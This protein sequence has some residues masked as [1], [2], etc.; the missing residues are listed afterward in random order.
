[1]KVSRNLEVTVDVLQSEN[2]LLKENN[3]HLEMISEELQSDVEII[4]ESVKMVGESTTEFMT[5]LRNNYEKLKQENDRHQK[6][7]RQQGMFQLMQLFKHFD[8]N[9]DFRLSEEE[10]EQNEIYLKSMFPNYD[11]N[12]FKSSVSY[13]ELCDALLPK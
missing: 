11:S 4:T 5:K 2:D 8:K 9:Q 13:S 7:N 12:M 6:L 3:K 1:M 10:L